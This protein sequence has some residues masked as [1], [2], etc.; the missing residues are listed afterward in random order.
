MQKTFPFLPYTSHPPPTLIF[1]YSNQQANLGFRQH[2]QE[3][4]IL[5]NTGKK[6]AYNEVY[7]KSL[8]VFQSFMKSTEEWICSSHILL[9]PYRITVC[10]SYYF[11]SKKI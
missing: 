1:K 10:D 8:E 7:L 9:Y 11:S 2:M 6:K 4:F 5:C 3:N